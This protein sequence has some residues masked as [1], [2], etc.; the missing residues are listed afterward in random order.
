[1]ATARSRLRQIP[2]PTQ[3]DH[4][5]QRGF[6]D[7]VALAR[8]AL[9][10][11]QGW[12]A[13]SSVQRAQLQ[14]AL[15]EALRSFEVSREECRILRMRLE[16]R[17][18][19]Q[20]PH[21]PPKARMA[22]LALRA[23]TG[24]TVEETA[25]R[26]QVTP[27]T[28]H[29]W[30]RRLDETKESGLLAMPVPVNKYPDFVEVLVKQLSRVAP[31]LGKRRIAEVLARAGLHLAPS[32]VARLRARRKPER[33]RP[34]PAGAAAGSPAGDG[35]ETAKR[36][37]SKRPH[38]VWNLDFTLL[39]TTP[40]WWVPSEV[41]SLFGAVTLLEGAGNDL[42][43]VEPASNDGDARWTLP[44]AGVPGRIGD[45]SDGL[46]ERHLWSVAFRKA[47]GLALNDDRFELV[48][49]AGSQGHGATRRSF[50]QGHGATPIRRMMGPPAGRV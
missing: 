8:K 42:D 3:W 9:F 30:M 31:L 41:S 2:I 16:A 23:G 24:W 18:A 11:V 38:H 48:V 12:A 44:R 17:P 1:M 4:W 26:F 10:V 14:G 29:N 20:R 37:T 33:K 13:N 36:V 47:L 22:I 35:V 7:A 27:M 19:Q 45:P 50:S 5:T 32:T 34:Q 43:L 28:L 15:A 6:L 25:R 21:Y 49:S 40:G 39:P 46:S